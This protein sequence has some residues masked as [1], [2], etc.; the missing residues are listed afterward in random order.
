MGQDLPTFSRGYFFQ[1][2]EYVGKTRPLEIT[3]THEFTHAILGGLQADIRKTSS[4]PITKPNQMRLDT[5]L[6]SSREINEIP[7]FVS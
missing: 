5:I 1:P 2:G 4:E 6:P 7:T 3:V